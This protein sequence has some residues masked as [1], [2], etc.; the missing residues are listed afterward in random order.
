MDW[1]NS[2]AQSDFAII[3]EETELLCILWVQGPPVCKPTGKQCPHAWAQRPLSWVQCPLVSGCNALLYGFCSN[4]LLGSAQTLRVTNLA[5]CLMCAITLCF[6]C[7]ARLPGY[8]ARLPVCKA[9]C[10]GCNARFQWVQVW[11]QSPPV[12]L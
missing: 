12:W 9:I 1:K 2:V 4:F 6:V 7:N 5:A 11:V 8:N 3:F 10:S